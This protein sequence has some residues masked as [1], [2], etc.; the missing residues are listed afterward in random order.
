ME[1][2]GIELADSE[3]MNLKEALE[4]NGLRYRSC[5]FVNGNVCRHFCERRVFG[6]GYCINENYVDNRVDDKSFYHLIRTIVASDLRLNIGDQSASVM[7]VENCCYSQLLRRKRYRQLVVMNVVW[8]EF[9]HE[10]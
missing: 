8:N 4:I 10:F 2:S 6:D 3:L 7:E 9:R 5:F 1:S